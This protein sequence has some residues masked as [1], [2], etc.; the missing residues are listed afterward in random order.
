MNKRSIIGIVIGII[1]IVVL[2]MLY[3]ADRSI[4]FNNAC[5]N[6]EKWNNIIASREETD[7]ELLTNI[8]FNDYDL[9]YDK[10]E[11]KWYY[12]IIENA[13]NGYNPYVK[14]EADKNVKIAFKDK[15]TS[16]LIEHNQNI[17][18]VAYTDKEY[19]KYL[20]VCTTLPIINI[21]YDE[22]TEITKYES[23]PMNFYLF[24]NREKSTQRVISSAGTI[25]SRGHST[26][27]YPKVGYKISLKNESMGNN[28]R[29][30]NIS[31]LGM[32]QDD[33]WY[34]YAGYN[35]Q[36]K[37]R[38]VF[39]TNLWYNSCARNNSYG[40]TNGV[41]YKYV[42]LFLN[43][44]YW[45]L[46]ALCFPV[47]DKQLSTS[48]DEYIFKKVRWN[49]LEEYSDE[50]LLQ[51]D[52]FELKTE[53]RNEADAWNKLRQAYKTMITS[54]NIY[55]LYKVSDINNSID[56]YLFLNLV[57]GLDNTKIMELNN[58]YLTIKNNQILYTTWD[59]DITWGNSWREKAKN[60]TD[61]YKLSPKENN[62]MESNV[63][64]CLNK[65]GDTKI[66]QLIKERYNELRQNEWSDANIIDV[67][68]KYENDIY[69][70]GAFLREEQR[71][72]DGTYSD[73]AVKL[74]NFK[75]YCLDRLKYM[76]EFVEKL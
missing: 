47:D 26:L 5:V 34:L 28:E 67:L 6:E 39:S 58:I 60:Y 27:D 54:N 14:I 66:N 57:Q 18:F 69:N 64:T 49:Y 76:D 51:L 12:S 31:L 4:A 7:E 65:L 45:G 25:H 40:I 10:K 75:Q 41:E 30:N 22:N 44:N 2:A 68:K 36:E 33:D 20:L 42:E 15:I 23:I 38:N 16:D 50:K 73:Y 35:D 56:T 70:S 8:K 37:V 17:E 11:N 21:D 3:F 1:S 19:H 62:V 55:E 48:N 61:S 52:G 9:L 74:S 71:W 63:I 46:Y 24:D 59:L 53:T 72:P 43:N 13:R 29:D 32:R